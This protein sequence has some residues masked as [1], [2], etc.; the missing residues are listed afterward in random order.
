MLEE[1]R[2]AQQ[3][4]DTVRETA[5]LD[6]LKAEKWVLEVEG[7]YFVI[8]IDLPQLYALREAARKAKDFSRADAI[9]NEFKAKGWLLEDTP[10]G[11]KLKQ[12]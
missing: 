5:V 7:K 3:R 1:Y 4:K 10:K 11:P 6:Q 12:I 2:A 9:R 8:P